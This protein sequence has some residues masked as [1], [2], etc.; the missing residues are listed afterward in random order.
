MGKGGEIDAN[1]LAETLEGFRPRLRR[2]LRLRM[3]PHLRARMDESDVLQEAFVEATRRAHE[4]AAAPD[5]PFFVWIRFLTVQRL[6]K[7]HR[8][9]LG[10]QARDARR[11]VPLDGR[12][13][14][15]ASSVALADVLQARGDTPSVALAREER[16]KRVI[17]ALEGLD[18]MDRE[19]LALRH[20]EGLSNA[21]CAHVLGLTGPGASRRYTRAAR[22][23]AARLRSVDGADA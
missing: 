14:P 23:L 2:M 20:F 6:G 22:R 11:E 9:H 16:R 13:G 12:L 7:A 8:R 5:V 19:I 3:A 18:A 1:R 21:E 17:A 15:E 4:Y 10:I